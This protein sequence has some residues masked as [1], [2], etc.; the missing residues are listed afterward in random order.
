M[1]LAVRLALLAALWLLGANAQQPFDYPTAKASTTWA[2]TDASLRH[3]VTFTDGSVARAALLR[4]NPARYG[5]SFAFG[6]FC[7]SPITSSTSTCADFLLGVAVVYCNSGALITSVTTGIPQIV[8]SA[9]RAVPVSDGAVTELTADGDL[10]LRSS[11]NGKTLWSTGTAGRG[12]AGISINSDGNLVIFDSSNR[13]VWQS[14]DHPTDTLVVG[15]SLTHG[16][17]LTANTSLTNSSESRVFLSVAVDR[18]AAYVSANP[19]QRYYD[20]GFNKNAAAYAKYNNGSLTVVAAGDGNAPPLATIQLPTA[21]AD[22]VQYMRLEHDGHLRVYE[23]RSSVGWESV[24]D[25]FHPYPNECAYPTVCGAYGVCTDDTQCSCPD[26]ANFRPVDFRRPNRGC[27]PT[28]APATCRRGGAGLVSLRDVAYFNGHVDTSLRAV[29]RVGEE[30]CKKACL[31]DCK[32]MAAQFV[33]GFDPSQGS[34]YLQSEVFSLE[35]MQPEIFHYNSTV[36]VKV[37]KARSPRRLL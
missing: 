37:A 23:W 5:P 13:T 19:P 21:G 20:I 12:V 4:L 36:H 24:A 1:L 31:D 2:N 14:F 7:R 9:N 6:F 29:E 28:A 32:C 34:C 18:L 10:V 11:P 16:A 3:H 27:V 30:A 33:Y 26:T 17:R 8:W 25:V 15:Q 35:T 22:T